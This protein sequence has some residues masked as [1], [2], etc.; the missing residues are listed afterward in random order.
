[1]T[2]ISNE[3]VETDLENRMEELISP[4]YHSFARSYFMPESHEFG[5]NVNWLHND[6]N[7]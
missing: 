3:S 1:M 4:T 5:I 2:E 7:T 6:L